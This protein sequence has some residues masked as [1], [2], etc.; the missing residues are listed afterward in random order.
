MMKKKINL[1]YIVKSLIMIFLSFIIIVPL[2]IMILGSVKNSQEAQLFNIQ[3][4]TEWVFEN[5]VHV[6]RIGNIGR[7]LANSVLITT[8]VVLVCVVSSA[9]AAF[10]IARRGGKYSSR[11][12][13][14]FMLGMVAP[15]QIVTTFGVLQVLGL[16]GTY[17]GVI[18]LQ[19]AIQIPWS[20]LI[21]TGFLK[22]VPRELD[23]A[24]YIDGANSLRV[25]FQIVLPLCKPILAT[26]I[27]AVAMGSWNEFMIPLYFFNTSKRWTMPLSVYNFFGMYGSQWNYVF[28]N[29]VLTAL[30]ITILY[31]C[32][33]KYVVAGA[34]AG[35]VKG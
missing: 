29:L 28:A 31:L 23:E 14:F 6:F 18:L 12:Y 15:L 21:L 24:A 4:P 25:F 3:L 19:V 27:V 22:S 13:T 7:A 5:Y 30:P 2:L 9:L 35:A 26:N 1:M 32:C 16:I 17:T 8:V 11:L 20:I 33:Q 34:T 10:I